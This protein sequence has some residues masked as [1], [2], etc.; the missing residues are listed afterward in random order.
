MSTE[1]FTMWFQDSGGR[2]SIWGR[3]ELRKYAKQYDFNADEVISV[4]ETK[5]LCEYGC[6]IAGGVFKEVPA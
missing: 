5:M 1:T 3:K 2:A 6:G 4:G